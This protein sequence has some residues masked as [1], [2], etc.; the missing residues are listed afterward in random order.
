M[1]LGFEPPSPR[2]CLNCL[3]GFLVGVVDIIV[4]VTFEGWWF[5]M[6]VPLLVVLV[7]L[8]FRVG[9]YLDHCEEEGW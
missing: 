7:P 6:L 5:L 4:I 1:R 8:Y 2:F 3:W 9:D